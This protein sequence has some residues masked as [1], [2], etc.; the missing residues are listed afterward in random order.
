MR[1]RGGSWGVGEDGSGAHRSVGRRSR[2]VA[3]FAPREGCGGLRRARWRRVGGASAASAARRR[4]VGGASAA[5]RRRVGMRRA[6]RGADVRGCGSQGMGARARSVHT[7][8]PLAPGQAARAAACTPDGACGASAECPTWRLRHSAHVPPA[9]NRLSVC[10]LLWR[11]RQAKIAPAERE[12]RA[13]E[14][15]A[16]NAAAA[17]EQASAASPASSEK[18]QVRVDVSTRR[19]GRRLGDAAERRE[20]CDVRRRAGAE[21]VARVCVRVRVRRR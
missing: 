7:G 14:K 9:P 18:P 20:R 4:R 6:R 8:E 10:R 2:A 21:R 12:R 5:R 19:S 1:G 13:A 17:A 3:P 15:K 16:P 11:V